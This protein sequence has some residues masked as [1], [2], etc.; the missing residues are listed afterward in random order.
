MR[1][2]RGIK[3]PSDPE[4]ETNFSSRQSGQ[5]GDSLETCEA[6][7]SFGAATK[8]LQAQ[9]VKLSAQVPV[10]HP[11]S[12]SLHLKLLAGLVVARVSS[13]K[14]HDLTIPQHLPW[15][16][17]PCTIMFVYLDPLGIIQPSCCRSLRDSPL[18]NRA[19]GLGDFGSSVVA[20]LI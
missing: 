15:H 6:A 9:R 20:G 13:H 2:D 10:V 3:S 17:G 1:S 14:R 19:L 4:P 5:N 18:F 12:L 11:C 16:L 8:T 7:R